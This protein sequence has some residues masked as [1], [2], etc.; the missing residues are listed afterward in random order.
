MQPLILIVV[1][2]SLAV[3]A[4]LRSWRKI[5]ASDPRRQYDLETI[6]RAFQA[7]H[8]VLRVDVDRFESFADFHGSTA[9]VADLTIIGD[10]VIRQANAN[11]API[12]TVAAHEPVGVR[13]PVETR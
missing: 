3:T 11:A 13:N 12:S 10:V 4:F 7:L 5:M 2:L 8:T 1:S 9:G 6:R